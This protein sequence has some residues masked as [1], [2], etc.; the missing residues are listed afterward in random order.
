MTIRRW[1]TAIVIAS[2][3]LVAAQPALAHEERAAG[4][5][6]LLVGL[7]GEPFLQG[8]RFGFE[9]WVTEAGRR[10]D[11]LERT[12]RAEVIRDGL[13]R[14]LPI[15]EREDAGHYEAEFKAPDDGAYALRLVGTVEGQVIDESF[16]FRLAP[17]DGAGTT[18][19]SVVVPSSGV[20]PGI[21]PLAVAGGVIVVAVAAG[22]FLVA[23]RSAPA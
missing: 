22:L 13:A 20:E 3:W 15:V 12:L 21:L 8:P 2:M 14:T 11:G 7:I 16:Q 1:L 23:R 6:T 17:P 18:G 4:R 19:G 5:Y 10:V 9:F